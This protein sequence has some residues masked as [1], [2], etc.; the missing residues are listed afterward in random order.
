MA[1]TVWVKARDEIFNTNSFQGPTLVP[2]LNVIHVFSI[3][4][5]RMYCSR[6]VTEE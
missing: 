6:E 2:Y 1:A 4:T 3:E 5:V